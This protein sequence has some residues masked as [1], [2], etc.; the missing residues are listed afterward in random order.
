MS[1]FQKEEKKSVDV[2]ASE[3]RCK[4]FVACVEIESQILP[5]CR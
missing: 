4:V 5:T 2:S 1:A 3:K